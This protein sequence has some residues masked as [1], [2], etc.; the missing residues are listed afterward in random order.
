MLVYPKIAV[1]SDENIKRAY[2]LICLYAY[3][4]ICLYAYIET[5]YGYFIASEPKKNLS[6]I[7][8]VITEKIVNNT[9]TEFL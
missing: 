5:F 3:M 4:L 1:K 9:S 8:I 6:R 7:Q 2:M